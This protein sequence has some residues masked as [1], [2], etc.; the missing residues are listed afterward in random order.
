MVREFIF[1]ASN[2]LTSD[3][4][5]S[6]GTIIFLILNPTDFSSPLHFNKP[7]AIKAPDWAITCLLCLQHELTKHGIFGAALKPTQD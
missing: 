4:F 6:A 1:N 5:L 2:C 7:A 3:H